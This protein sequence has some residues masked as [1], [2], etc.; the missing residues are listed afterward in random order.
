MVW[1]VSMQAISDEIRAKVIAEL[2][3]GSAVNATARKYKLSPA[4]VSRLK[5]EI[6]PQAL[7]QIETEKRVRI[8]DLLLESVANHLQALDRIAGYVSTPEY[9]AQKEP[10]ALAAL[11]E[12][13]AVTPL[14]ILEAASAAGLD[15]EPDDSG[16]G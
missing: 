9:L 1:N 12:K 16:I 3:A 11:Y 15:G 2:I 4:T 13:L 8:D 7:K 6:A 10:T 14:S 5:N